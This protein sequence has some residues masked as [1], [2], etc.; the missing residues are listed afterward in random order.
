MYN[1]RMSKQQSLQLKFERICITL[2][3]RHIKL[4]QKSLNMRKVDK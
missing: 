4:K 3:I 2:R 1:V